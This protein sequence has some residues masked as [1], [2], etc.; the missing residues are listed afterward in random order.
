MDKVDLKDYIR[1]IENFPIDGVVFKDITP[2]LKCPIAFA[3]C[4]DQ[5]IEAIEGLEFDAIV[6]PEARG[7]IFGTAVALKLGKAIIPVRKKGKLPYKTFEKTY[8]LEYGTST[9]EIHQDAF[10]KNK[11][12]IIID[13]VLATG[14]TS[15]AIAELIENASG[16]VV[17][18]LYLMGLGFLNG[19]EVLKDYD[20][21]TI[22]EY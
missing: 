15:N 13:D 17:S 12:A 9:L 18:I 14:G 20:V 11:K 19:R 16:E 8:D 6:V 5:M 4:I 3:S 21:K 2:L 1:D 10:D 7:F 22:I